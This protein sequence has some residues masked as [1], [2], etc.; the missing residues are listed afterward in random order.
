MR[1]GEVEGLRWRNIDFKNKLFLLDDTK[2]GEPRNIPMSDTIYEM[3]LQFAHDVKARVLQ[4][5]KRWRYEVPVQN[6]SLYFRVQQIQK[7]GLIF[8]H[9]LKKH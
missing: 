8:V 2:N 5:S 7:N 6:D 1:K 9:P 4:R 3:L